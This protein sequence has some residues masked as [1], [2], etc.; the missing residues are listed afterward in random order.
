MT[1]TTF[2]IENV[3]SEVCP[4]A[5]L[6]SPALRAQNDPDSPLNLKIE[7]DK[8]TMSLD[9]NQGLALVD[10][11]KIADSMLYEAKRRGR[12]QVVMTT[13]T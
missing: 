9:E 7:E 2:L 1:F 8:I 11:I 6:V 5:F 10:F 12:N 4:R 13:A 3:S